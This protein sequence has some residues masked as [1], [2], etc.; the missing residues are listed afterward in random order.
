MTNTAPSGGSSRYNA[1]IADD[2]QIVRAGLRAALEMPGLVEPE[3]IEVMAEAGDGPAAIAAI[4]RC[5]PHLLLLDVSMP[6][7]GGVEVVVETRRWSPE[8]KIAVFTGVTAP[9]IVGSLVGSGIDGLFSKAAPNEYMYQK[10]PLI[11]RGGKAIAPMFLDILEREPRQDNLTD[12]ERQTLN[13]IVRGQSNKEI[14][15]TLGISIKTVDKHRT[16]LM[17]KLRVNSVA[18]L[19]ARAVKD[20]LID[21]AK[22]L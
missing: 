4:R 20:G 6:G 12:R 15:E 13:C 7:A 19:L 21:P 5:R 8:T 1:V 10:L 9:G 2:H 18:Q 11:L 14:A 16:S 17:Q 3:G 22:E